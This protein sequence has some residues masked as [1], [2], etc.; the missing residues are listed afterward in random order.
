MGLII[1]EF[2]PTDPED[3]FSDI[4][5]QE[6]VWGNPTLL[7]PQDKFM[8]MVKIAVPTVV[9]ILLIVFGLSNTGSYFT[10]A[11]RFAGFLADIFYTWQIGTLLAIVGAI[12]VYDAVKRI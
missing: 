9:G 8:K 2:D 1:E 7:S 6:K 11:G 5:T 4:P 3:L 12:L 10:P